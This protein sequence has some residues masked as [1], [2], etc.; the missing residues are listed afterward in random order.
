MRILKS[1][2]S[3]A[4]IL[5]IIILIMFVD[6]VYKTYT[7]KQKDI[8]T[9]AIV[10]FAGGKGR[11]EEAIRLF[12]TNKGEYLFLVGLDPS[13][14]LKDI[15][16]HKPKDPP[17]EKIILE[18]LSKNTFENALFSR[19]LL[20]EKN[21]KSIQLITSRYHMKRS[22]LLLRSALPKNVSIHS[23]PVDT[24]NLKENW[25]SDKA[26]LILLSKE[27]YKYCAI[28]L[29]LLLSPDELRSKPDK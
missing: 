29:Y 24:A 17:I 19:D 20:V 25:W 14:R 7:Y 12:R 11:I 8:K 22:S 16:Q 3:L 21:I 28:K 5:S 27:F 6:F 10:V 1:I 18:K 9:D 26:S 15:Y 2:L 4:I 23:Y 13:V